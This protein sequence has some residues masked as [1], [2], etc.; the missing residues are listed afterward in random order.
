MSHRGD[1]QVY[2]R[3][4]TYWICYWHRGRRYRESAKTDNER[5]ARKLLRERLTDFG[6]G[7]TAAI[8][9]SKVTFEQMA[10]S[11]LNDYRTNRKR[12]L[13][14][15]K[16]A[17]EHLHG[18]FGDDLAVDIKTPRIREFIKAMQKVR[19]RRL[20]K[21]YS[22]AAINRYLSAL[23]RMFHLM[24]QDTLLETAPYVPM[25]EENNTRQGT[26]EPGDF[27]RVCQ[28][29][30]DYLR[31]AAEFAYLCGWRKGEVRSLEWRDINLAVPEIRLR[32]ENSKNK[33]ARVIPLTGRLLE[34]V[35]RACA[36]R[37]LDCPFVFHRGNQSIGDFRKAWNA[38]RKAAGQH[39]L[40]FH[41]LRRSGVTNMRR[42]GMDE[43]TAM[44]VSGHKTVS[45]F[46]RYKIEATRDIQEGLERLDAYIERTV[47]RSKVIPLRS[48]S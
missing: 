40:L 29:L 23:K 12:T 10:E 46:R 27:E 31:P 48:V 22:N 45:T 4:D 30:P 9:S 1:G 7:K 20:P 34:I 43:S 16:K 15:A 37:R 33:T 24:I 26:I 17:V 42:A 19:T 39:K 14:S 11:Y 13:V 25:L 18:F 3:G 5:I 41:D 35:Q 2:K 21:G 32:P 36:D 44:K 6:R 28:F 47:D 38:A 8:V